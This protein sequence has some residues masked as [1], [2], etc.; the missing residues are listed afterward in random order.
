MGYTLQWFVLV[1]TLVLVKLSIMPYCVDML[2]IIQYMQP[3]FE[4]RCGEVGTSPEFVL[5]LPYFPLGKV[6]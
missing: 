4:G 1:R 3:D 5:H 6:K 2:S